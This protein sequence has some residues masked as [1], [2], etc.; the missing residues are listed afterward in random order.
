MHALQDVTCS[1]S[2]TNTCKRNET[3]GAL[4]SNNRSRLNMLMREDCCNRIRPLTFL[5]HMAWV[6]SVIIYRTFRSLLFFCSV[7]SLFKA[8]NWSS[9]QFPY[10]LWIGGWWLALVKGGGSHNWPEWYRYT[11]RIWFWRW[12]CTSTNVDPGGYLTLLLQ[13]WCV[14]RR[15][16]RVW[17]GIRLLDVRLTRMITYT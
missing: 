4:R 11:R 2:S 6:S 3:H 7:Y 16:C 15:S 5:H 10:G 17:S 12:P 14:L 8:D 1:K 9:C 13:L